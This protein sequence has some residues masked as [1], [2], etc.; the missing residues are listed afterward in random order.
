MICKSPNIN[1]FQN[2]HPCRSIS[3]LYGWVFFFCHQ[4]LHNSQMA[5]LQTLS[6][7]IHSYVV[8]DIKD[9]QLY[10][11]PCCIV[12]SYLFR[13]SLVIHIDSMINQT[14]YHSLTDS[15]QPISEL[16]TI[17]LLSPVVQGC[18]KLRVSIHKV[19]TKPTTGGG[20]TGRYLVG[21]V[22]RRGESSPCEAEPILVISV[23]ALLSSVTGPEGI[24]NSRVLYK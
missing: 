19:R 4:L 15:P 3:T 20:W 18:R 13:R 21:L 7:M 6:S 8:G 5:A 10:Q 1:F 22:K 17:F 11:R 24:T 23:S 12:Y 9:H 2:L 16:P 14:S